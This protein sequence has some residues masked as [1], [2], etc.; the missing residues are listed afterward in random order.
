[1]RKMTGSH[2]LV[3][4]VAGELHDVLLARRLNKLKMEQLLQVTGE[5]LGEEHQDVEMYV[6]SLFNIL[7]Y[8]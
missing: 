4:K 6:I 8:I 5:Y 1:M 3:K 7:K 2:P